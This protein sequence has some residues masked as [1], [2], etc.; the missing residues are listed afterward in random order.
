MRIGAFLCHQA[1][2]QVVSA[3]KVRHI[4]DHFKAQP[5][6]YSCSKGTGH[7]PSVSVNYCHSVT[8]FVTCLLGSSHCSFQN[9]SQFECKRASIARNSVRSPVYTG[10][11]AT[12]LKHQLQYSG[13]KSDLATKQS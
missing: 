11:Q 8:V 4:Q 6:M 1:V 10:V 7:T 5:S 13:T 9:A 12:C 2:D 3:E